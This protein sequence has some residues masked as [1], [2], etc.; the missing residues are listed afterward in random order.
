MS[1]VMDSIEQIFQTVV[2]AFE[3]V[4]FFPFPVPGLDEGIPFLV[5]WLLIGGIFFTL[6]LGFNNFRMMAHGIDVIRGKYK[7][8][9]GEGEISSFQAV[10]TVVSGTVGVGGNIAGVAI[11]V[12]VGGP[13]AVIWIMIAG[14]LCTAN[15]FAE[16]IVGQKYRHKDRNG[17]WSGGAWHYLVDGLAETPYKSVGKLLAILFAIFCVGGALGGGNMFQSNQAVE[18]ITTNYPEIADWGWIVAL[19]MAIKVGVVLIGGIGR[20]ARVTEILVPFMA[21]IYVVACIVVLVTNADLI[22]DAFGI[23][24][25]HA[26]TPEAAGGGMMGALIIGLRRAF[27]SNEAGVGSAPIVHA[28]TRNKQPVRE[29]SAAIIEPIID[30]VLI[31]TMTGLVIVITG[32]YNNVDGMTGVALTSMAFETVIPWFPHVLTIC[33]LLFAF[34]TALTWSYYGERAWSYLTN[35]RFINTYYIIFCALTFLGGVA[36]LGPVVSLSDLMLL[37]M[38]VPNLIGLYLMSN[39]IAR[40]VREYKASLAK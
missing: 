8:E 7:H 24:I 35:G 40:E 13:G 19:I 36:E 1:S 30:S 6:R 16:V 10:A 17:K 5:L 23:M 12:S 22:S 4:L 39:M 15:K 2:F 37:S 27:F 14:L 20:I 38:A 11:A 26:F 33:V 32:A 31:C 29:A 28:A 18:I 9:E 25:H 3:S 34:S 21:F